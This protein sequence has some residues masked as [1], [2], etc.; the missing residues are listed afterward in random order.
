M[1]EVIFTV[2]CFLSLASAAFSKDYLRERSILIKEYDGVIKIDE[3]SILALSYTLLAQSNNLYAQAL[4]HFKIGFVK[5][6]RNDLR[7]A[8]HYI[9]SIH[10]LDKADTSD[11]F[12]DM[13]V[14]KNLGVIFK[15]HGDY[16][17]GIRYYQEALPFAAAYDKILPYKKQKYVMSLKYNMANAYSE[18]YNPKAIDLYLEVLEEA[19]AKENVTKIAQTNNSMGILFHDAKEYNLA[20][21][22]YNEVLKCSHAL[23][24]NKIKE[25]IGYANQN[26]GEVYFKMARMDLAE[27]YTLKS[28]EYLEE[29]KKFGPLVT[30]TELHSFQNNNEKAKMYGEQALKIYP[31]VQKNE[32]RLRIFELMADLTS[33]VDDRPNEYLT[34]MLVE[35]KLMNQ[36]LNSLNNLKDKENLFRVV[37]SYYREL[38]A[39]QRKTE[40][41]QWIITGCAI[42][43]AII[44]MVALYFMIM[45]KRKKRELSD[46]AEDGSSD[47]KYY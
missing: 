14:R 9:E 20:I 34:K 3:D 45:D 26:L 44:A 2:V 40:Y 33:T 31:Q 4:A 36:E 13:A 10:L 39:N 16:E 29:D 11:V 7:A 32:D 28:L 22:H 46:L 41:R 23:P 1:R 43:V 25:Y 37:D 18:N 8:A 24:N 42:L 30:L 21:Q 38:E 47:F 27:K 12:L 15:Q 6:N 5:E 17:S 35:Q 19:K